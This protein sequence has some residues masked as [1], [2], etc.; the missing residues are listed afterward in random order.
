MLAG[1][2]GAFAEPIDD[3]RVIVDKTVT[4]DQFSA[5]FTSI[6]GLMLGNMQN[7]VAKSG[8]SLSDDAAAVVVEM[9]TTQ[10]VDA[11]LERMREPL[12]KAY[13]LNLSPEAIA[14]YR[15]FLETEAGGEVAAATPQIMLESSKIGEEIGGEIAGEAVRAMV[16]EMEAGNWPSGT[17]KSTQAELRDLYVLPEVAE[18]PAER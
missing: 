9:L 15:A 3:A 16:A 18:M 4:R 12:A 5:A 14:A 13:V 1:A 11:I 10:M 2:P 7:E 17:L 8:K 6:A